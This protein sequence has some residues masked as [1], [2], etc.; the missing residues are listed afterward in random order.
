M[1]SRKA[2]VT[3]ASGFIAGH[4]ARTLGAV[5]CELVLVSR[6]PRGA[7]GARGDRVRWLQT[8]LTDADRLETILRDEAPEAIFHLAGTRG[9]GAAR[10]FL[11]CAEVNLCGTLR[12]LEAARR[13]AP[14][15]RILLTGSAEEYGDQA[16]QQAETLPLQP[17]TPYGLSK[18][19]ATQVAQAMH[20]E[21]GCRVVILR[22]FSVYGPGQPDDMFVAEAV[23]CAVRGVPFRMSRGEQRRDLIFVQDVVDAL[24]A[25]AS[26][27]DIDGSVINVGSG[28]AHRLRDVAQR[29]W[30]LAGSRAPLLIGAREAPASEQADTWADIAKARD[31]LRWEPRVDLE[32]GLELTVRSAR[33]RSSARAAP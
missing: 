3:G 25:A 17:S 1:T 22:L 31:L 30:E 20:A 2:L 24:V 33:E 23:D 26:A 21:S 7:D 8:D 16:G 13:A 29:I 12:V 6:S 15:A 28:H 18:A 19:A 32:R 27:P 9:R 4:L 10:P 11:A 5:G 14:A